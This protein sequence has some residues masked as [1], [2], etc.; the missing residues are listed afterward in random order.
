MKKNITKFAASFIYIV[1]GAA[2]IVEPGLVED[3]FSYLLAA[4]AIIIGLLKLVSYLMTRVET[5]IAEDTNGFAVGVSLMILG[6]FVLMESTMFILL[7]PFI[8]GFM[9]TF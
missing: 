7:V 9:I 4:A 3:M 2:L 6:I 5:R 8:L 1:L